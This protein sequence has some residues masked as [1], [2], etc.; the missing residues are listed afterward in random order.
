MGWR[1]QATPIRGDE[2]LQ[3]HGPGGI[4]QPS[5][6]SATGGFGEISSFFADEGVVTWGDGSTTDYISIFTIS[7]TKCSPDLSVQEVNVKRH[8]PLEN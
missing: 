5:A 8:G 7:G 6:E 2:Y 3:F 1:Q 4:A